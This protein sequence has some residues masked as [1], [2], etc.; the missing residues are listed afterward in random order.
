MRLL[1]AGAL[2]LMTAAGLAA[3]RPALLSDEDRTAASTIRENRMRADVRFLSRDLLEGRG[4]ATRGDRLALDYLVTRFEAI[5]LEPGAPGGGWE[6]GLDAL[7]ATRVVGR[8]PG[9]D[10][11]LSGEAVVYIVHHDGLGAGRGRKGEPAAGSAAFGGAAGLATMLAVAEAFVALP[12]RP[13]RSILF[14]AVAEEGRPAP[15]TLGSDAPVSTGRLSANFDVNGTRV[16][17]RL[18]DVP[19]VGQ[20]KSSLDDWV[21]AIAETQGRVVIPDLVAGW[22]LSGGVEDARLLF[23]LGAK[24]AEAP[25]ASP[26]RPGDDIAGA[27]QESLAELGR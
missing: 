5:G 4:P 6:Q 18:G 26:W 7:G 9:R 12:E 27:G 25:V 20:G 13:R 24:L 11:V 19:V 16:R 15:A 21:R 17:G 8:I 3:I 10:P 1:L 23:L 2:A 22:N 14:A